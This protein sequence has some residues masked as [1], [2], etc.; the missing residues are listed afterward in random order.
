MK[1]TLILLFW[2][3]LT[4]SLLPQTFMPLWPDNQTPNSKG[5]SLDYVEERERITQVD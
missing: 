2:F 5:L 4:P 1:K 3:G